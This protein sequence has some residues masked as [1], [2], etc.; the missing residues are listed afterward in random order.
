MKMVRAIAK[1]MVQSTLATTLAETMTAF[2]SLAMV[3]NLDPCALLGSH[4]PSLS[5]PLSQGHLVNGSFQSWLDSNAGKLQ[6]AP[7][8]W[9]LTIRIPDNWLLSVVWIFVMPWSSEQEHLSE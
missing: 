3:L 5:W 4:N 9:V 7:P 8:D 6:P 1:D 2:L